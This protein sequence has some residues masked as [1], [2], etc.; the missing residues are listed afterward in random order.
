MARREKCRW[1]LHCGFKGWG[2]GNPVILERSKFQTHSS[3]HDSPKQIVL[4][5]RTLLA[6]ADPG[7]T[8]SSKK[9]LGTK[10]I[11][12]NGAIGRYYFRD[13][14]QKPGPKIYPECSS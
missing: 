14:S 12:T 5:E 8:T 10:G 6:V 1:I 11:A 2:G 9:L 7:I 13:S 3:D 4:G